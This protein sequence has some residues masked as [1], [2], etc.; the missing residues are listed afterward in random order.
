MNIGKNIIGTSTPLQDSI[1]KL[2][3]SI[4]IYTAVIGD[5]QLELSVA[6][7]KEGQNI[8]NSLVTM[9]NRMESRFDS[10][11]PEIR[12]LAGLCLQ[13]LRNIDW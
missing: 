6:I 4:Q 13:L 8:Q 1:K 3:E 7:F 11:E 2:N 5:L 12:T 9:F 10:I